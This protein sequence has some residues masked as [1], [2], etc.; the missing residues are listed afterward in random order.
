MKKTFIV[1]LNYKNYEDTYACIESIDK[2][3]YFQEGIQVIIVDNFSPDESYQKLKL[4][5]NNFITVLQSEYNGGFSYGNN[6]GIRYA[7]ECGADYVLLINNDTLVTVG[8]VDRLIAA[9]QKNGDEAIVS[10]KILRYPETNIIWYGGGDVS[11]ITFK[12]KHIGIN[13][14]D[15]DKYSKIYS[16]KY[17]C[18]CCMLISRKVINAIGLLPEEYF[19]YCEDLDYS[20]LATRNNIKL[21]YCGEA[22]LYHKVSISCGGE[23]SK[24]SLQYIIKNR[25][26]LIKKYG[27]RQRELILALYYFLYYVYKSIKYAWKGNTEISLFVLKSY[28]KFLPI[29]LNKYKDR[30]NK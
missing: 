17:I 29:L 22:T 9:C 16:T 14:K 25:F 30:E 13:C 19:M 20:L 4:I 27:N 3:G 6:I 24:F 5:E 2:C 12:T 11:K 18:G 21:V 8:M 23:D 15:C 7:M 1:L 26:L 28:F 10:S